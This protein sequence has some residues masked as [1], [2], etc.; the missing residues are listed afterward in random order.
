MS[1][2]NDCF[3]KRFPP[4]GAALP[5]RV[6]LFKKKAMKISAR[7][8]LKGKILEVKKGATTSHVRLEIAPGQVITSSITKEAVDELG[9]KVGG[10]A[11]AII[12]ASRGV[13]AVDWEFIVKTAFIVIAACAV[14][15]PAF[16]QEPVGCDKFK[17]PLDKGRATLNGT[18]LP[19]I[20][21][22]AS[23]T[24]PIPFGTIVAL[25]PLADAKLPA[26]PERTPK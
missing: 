18:E 1:F 9:F 3:P 14:A 21:S 25:K 23:V 4:V 16:A 6:I 5:R 12:K 15:V 8:Q 10:T 26:P 7:N 24:F 19:K 20:A 2:R 13:I 22:G 11:T 17:W